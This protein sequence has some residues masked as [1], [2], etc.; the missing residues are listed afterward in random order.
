MSDRA[1]AQLSELLSAEREAIRSAAFDVLDD[2]AAQ[3]AQIFATLMRGKPDRDQM[4]GIN[5]QMADNQTLL[6][7]AITGI[8]AARSRIE[9]LRQVRQELSVYDQSGQMA[10]VTALHPGME[11]KA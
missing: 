11:K 5:R 4:A 7:A 6:A 8:K 2:L 3:K 9:T 1:F 10:K